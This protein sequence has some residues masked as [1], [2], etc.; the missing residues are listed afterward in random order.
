MKRIWLFFVLALMFSDQAFA[1]AK[2]DKLV[3]AGPKSSVTH[4][5]AYVI[6]AGLLNDIAGE[7]ELII[8]DNPDQLRALMVRG[9]VHFTAV[10][11]HVASMLY[12]KGVPVRLLN[13][14]NWGILYIVSSNPGIKTISDLK[15]EEVVLTYRSDMPDVVLSHLARKQGLEPGKDFMLRYLPSFPAAAQELLTGRAKHA[16]LVEPLASM[17]I[18]K[19]SAMK[20]NSPQLFRAVDLQEEW[21][22]VYHSEPKIAISGTCALAGALTSPGVI[23]RFQDAYKQAIVWCKRHP[24]EAAKIVTKHIPGVKA[25][26][27]ALGLKNARLEFV[28]AK[29][30]RP[31]VEQFLRVLKS[32]NPAKIGGKLPGDDFYWED[33]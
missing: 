22:K 32:V 27:V 15:G 4:P 1:L 10:P 25:P 29:D 30:A 11:S 16:L 17:S 14:A 26:S 23:K 7:V 18:A 13:I 12:N 19:S 28:T 8:W 9:H 2:M 24:K 5:L 21:G 3:L 33:K 31:Q 20:G 6:E